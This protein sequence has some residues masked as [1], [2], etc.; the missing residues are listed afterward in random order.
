MLIL[1]RP[2][3]FPMSLMDRFTSELNFGSDEDHP[4]TRADELELIN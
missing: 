4:V 2:G 1:K 3:G